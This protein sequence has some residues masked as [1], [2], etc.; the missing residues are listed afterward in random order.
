LF[1]SVLSII[2][3]KDNARR[4]AEEAKKSIADRDAIIQKRAFMS[5]FCMDC[6]QY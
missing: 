4:N 6:E 2:K 1:D 5:G 3:D